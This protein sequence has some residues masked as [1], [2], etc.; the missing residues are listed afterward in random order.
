MEVPRL[1]LIPAKCG[2]QGCYY[3]EHEGCDV[4]KYIEVR[5]LPI[6]DPSLWDCGSTEESYIFVPEGAE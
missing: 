1:K 6:P 4:D 5:G 3:D 2:C